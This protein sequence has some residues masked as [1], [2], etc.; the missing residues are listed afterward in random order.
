M[1]RP[2]LALALVGCTSGED[3][4]GL[5][6]QAAPPPFVLSA[7]DMVAGDP[8]A[9]VA[10]SLDG[11]ET[12]WFFVS[13]AGEGTGPCDPSGTTCLDVVRPL[14]L[15]SASPDGG[16]E[17]TLDLTVPATVPDGTPVWFQVAVRDASGGFTTA[18]PVGAVVSAPVSEVCDL[19]AADHPTY[20]NAALPLMLPEDSGIN[21]YDLALGGA[22]SGGLADAYD[23][24]A[25][26]LDSGCRLDVYATTSD[27][28]S[29]VTAQVTVDG[30]ATPVAFG[31]VVMAGHDGADATDATLQLFLDD[32]DTCFTYDLTLLY[33]CNDAPLVESV[34]VTVDG[35]DLC[36]TWTCAASTSDADGDD[37][38][39]GYA[40]TVD[41][42]DAGVST[43]TFDG[44]QLT[45]G[46]EVAC[47]VTAVDPWGDVATGTATRVAE[48]AD[49]IVE[50]V[51][52]TAPGR[53]GETLT[54]EATVQACTDPTLTYTW[55]VDGLDA[56]VTGDALDTS[57]LAV[58]SEVSCAV[59]AFDG[60][61]TVVATSDSQVLAPR[62]L[63]L[64]ATEPGRLGFGVAIMPDLDGDGYGLLAAGAPTYSADLAYGGR[65]YLV[66][67]SLDAETIDVALVEDGTYGTV[68]DGL[69]GEYD[70]DLLACGSVF[71]VGG[72]PTSTDLE[73]WE[74]YDAG[75]P[76]SGF[77]VTVRAGTDVDGDGLPDLVAS[78]PFELLTGIWQGRSYVISGATLG[79]AQ[80]S[81]I[82]DETSL[83]GF[84][85]DG[86]CGRRRDENDE[87]PFI[88]ED[89]YINGD[90]AGYSVSALDDV[91]GDGL[92]DLMVGAHN[93]G[94]D[95]RG[96]AYIVYGRDDGQNVDLGDLYSFGCDNDGGT[97]PG[98]NAANYGLALLGRDDGGLGL[99]S[100]WG[101]ATGTAGDFDGDGYADAIFGGRYEVFV[102]IM[103]G[104]PTGGVLDWSDEVRLS[105]VTGWTIATTGFQSSSDG[106]G[107]F[108]V[109][110]QGSAANGGGDFNGDGL[111]DVVVPHLDV[112]LSAPFTVVFGTTEQREISVQAAQLG[113]GSGGVTVVN[114]RG[115]A[116]TRRSSAVIMGDINGDGLDD[117]AV[118]LPFSSRVVLLYGRNDDVFQVDWTELQDGSAGFIIDGTD[119]LGWTV[120]GGDLDGD[121]LDDLVMGAPGNSDD[122]PG[123]VQVVFGRDLTGSITDFGGAGDDLLRGTASA[124]SMVGGHG[125]DELIGN[126][127]PDVLYGGAGD[128]IL[129]VADLGFQRVRGGTGTDT[130][131]FAPQVGAIDMT[132]FDAFVDDIEVLALQGQSITVS[133]LELL[134]LS[135][136]SNQL[137]VTGTGTLSTVA[138]ETW[139]QTGTDTEDGVTYL[140]LTNG[141]AIL[142][143][144]DMLDTQIPPSITTRALAFDENPA[145]GQVVGTIAAT[146]P[147]GTSVTFAITGGAG[148]SVL[149]IDPDTGDLSVLDAGPLDHED[150]ELDVDLQV[151]VTDGEGLT[152]TV[153]VAITVEDVNEAPVFRNEVL[154]VGT[155][156][157]SG[158]DGTV[159]ATVLATDADDGDSFSYSLSGVDAGLFAIDTDGQIT[160]ATGA[161]LDFET[162]SQHVFSAVATDTSGLTDVVVVTVDVYDIDVIESEA[163][164]SLSTAN[165]SLFVDGGDA[166][167]QAWGFG[168]LISI[169]GSID[170]GE[171]SVE[172]ELLPAS[173]LGFAAN[174]GIPNVSITANFWGELCFSLLVNGD[175]GGIDVSLPIDVAL[176]FP[177]E[178]VEGETF[179]ISTGWSVADGGSVSGTKP[180]F[181]VY[182]YAGAVDTN[183][184]FG[185]CLPDG[186]LVNGF[187]NECDTVFSIY[188]AT[189][190]I[191]L[192]YTF[193]GGSWAAD[194]VSQDGLV[195]NQSA[196]GFDILEDEIPIDNALDLLLTS[197]GL[198]N[199]NEGTVT[200]TSEV[201]GNTITLEGSYTILHQDMTTTIAQSVDP[202]FSLDG[203][204][205]RIT[206]EDGSVELFDLGAGTADLTLPANAD[207]D[208]DGDV[209][210]AIAL[211]PEARVNTAYRQAYAIAYAYEQYAI[212]LTAY[213]SLHGVSNSASMGPIWES[214][215]EDE[216]ALGCFSGDE[217]TTYDVSVSG[218]NEPVIIGAID[219]ATGSN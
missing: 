63:T 58:G 139:T 105:D 106:N 124:D 81:D 159:I 16:G 164:L 92:A 161:T 120:E 27:D 102:H 89:A 129:E 99:G 83:A 141:R 4:L 49:V 95:N 186:D 210:V 142:R 202:V 18:T 219:I 107:D 36:G 214:S 208:G 131:R 155:E 22:S 100:Q 3:A 113:V 21:L 97:G 182:Y 167:E 67:G 189:S 153:D 34:G 35:Q 51:G 121:G 17:A 11:D 42:V 184:E 162:A 109:L 84:A 37:L 23:R 62:T 6:P 136:L 96:M 10:A 205:G 1:N 145:V 116:S 143:V 108:G 46:A 197:L 77:G 29:G 166:Y 138:G 44:A 41:G 103:P 5:R 115:S 88:D 78:S 118:G 135:T 50:H 28:A 146:D 134:N 53:Q 26:P 154:S 147:D 218:W 140:V 130:L 14:F 217:T 13:V 114:G 190:E 117:A 148:A 48:A 74:G 72:C 73:E 86:E 2:I 212:S 111:D 57:L 123:Y 32:T 132:T 180:G 30:T 181:R 163:R 207:L 200:A 177:D 7:S 98:N 160:I 187:T 68:F 209:D 61:T 56:G 133:T 15:G 178:V 196:V 76:G 75:P 40:W 174:L 127:G 150:D 91:N 158:G 110:L 101:W 211:V 104:G 24:F 149:A 43:A 168:E 137:D 112:S 8:A 38:L 60:S 9:L 125:D 71:Y 25:V 39:L 54:C 206:Y 87:I 69:N 33:T 193:G 144:D 201:Q 170:E 215:C 80:L 185:Y 94:D 192:D 12:A 171:A 66:D 52:I 55:T 194:V 65:L 191:T 152:T 198:P 188:G 204:L 70:L 20:V 151:T 183:W 90:L 173:L 165:R 31:D 64:V 122:D 216:G 59:S 93:A 172:R 47:T 85:I 45:A 169:C 213:D 79:A 119:Q 157:G 203:M 128:D 179:T 199:A 19:D 156:E 195:W 126:G 175:D 176:G 82:S